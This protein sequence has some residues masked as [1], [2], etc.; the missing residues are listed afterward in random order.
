LLGLAAVCL[1]IPSIYT[2]LAGLAILAGATALNRKHP[3]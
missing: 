1:F 2:D 3:A